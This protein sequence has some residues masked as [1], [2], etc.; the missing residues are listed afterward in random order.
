MSGNGLGRRLDRLEALRRRTGGAD[1]R[2]IAEEVAAD[3]GVDVDGALA[4]VEWVIALGPV[5]D[6]QFAAV[7]ARDVAAETGRPVERVR[8][9]L[10]QIMREQPRW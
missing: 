1:P 5:S 8:A 6:D 9:E 4:S 2:R 3:L 10:E 7:L